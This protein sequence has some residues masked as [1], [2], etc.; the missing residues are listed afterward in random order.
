VLSPAADGGYVLIGLR[1]FSPG[2]FAHVNW[3]AATTLLDTLQ[4]AKE[5]TLSVT[6]LPLWYD[7]DVIENLGTLISL[8]S[9]DGS[10]AADCPATMEAI[11]GRWSTIE[12]A[13][14]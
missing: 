6:L 1:S 13:L 11:Q 7:I 12:A 5:A 8:Q 9:Q 14:K 3:S 2:M 4:A 10:E